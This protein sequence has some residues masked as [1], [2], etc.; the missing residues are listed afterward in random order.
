MYDKDSSSVDEAV[1]RKR[2]KRKRL[3]EKDVEIAEDGGG[4][5]CRAVESSMSHGEI[6]QLESLADQRQPSAI[7]DCERGKKNMFTSDEDEGVRL[8]GELCT[9][10]GDDRKSER[11]RRRKRKRRTEGSDSASGLANAE[12]ERDIPDVS[13]EKKRKRRDKDVM[14]VDGEVGKSRRKMVT[15]DRSSGEQQLQDS[16]HKGHGSFGTS[17]P[18]V[19][20]ISGKDSAKHSSHKSKHKHKLSHE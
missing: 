12:S 7:A 17:Q 19:E 11:K 14:M 6:G 13:R 4:G 8:T 10:R 16:T 1:R 15:L 3:R 5:E 2:K 20:P 9:Q 18:Q